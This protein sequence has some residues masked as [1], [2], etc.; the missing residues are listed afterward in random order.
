MNPF[1][2]LS[3]VLAGLLIS[4]LTLNRSWKF[5]YE[6]LM[7][8]Q[9]YDSI[10]AYTGEDNPGRCFSSLKI[11]VIW[12]AV[13]AVFSYLTALFKNI[14]MLEYLSVCVPVLVSLLFILSSA[15][16]YDR[17]VRRCCYDGLSKKEDPP[18]SFALHSFNFPFSVPAAYGVAM[19]ILSIVNLL[20]G[21]P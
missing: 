19:C 18:S 1:V 6:D 12:V 17:L 14:K 5:I 16:H 8:V 3:L 2:F 7:T 9:F 13:S 10:G 11:D 4:F 20:G 15:S 21:A